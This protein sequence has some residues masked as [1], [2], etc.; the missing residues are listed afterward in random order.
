[1]FKLS[2]CWKCEEIKNNHKVLNN[3]LP[4][5]VCDVLGKYDKCQTCKASIELNQHY[6]KEYTENK[7]HFRARKVISYL[8][9]QFISDE[10]DEPTFTTRDYRNI[11]KRT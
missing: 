5:N 7:D 2:Y 3:K 6:E 9:M 8:L 4:E 1:M 11:I 10:Y